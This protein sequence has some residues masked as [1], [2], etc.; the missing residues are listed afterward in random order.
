[1]FLQVWIII[2][3]CLGNNVSKMQRL[4]S[5]FQ[6]LAPLQEQSNKDWC[7]QGSGVTNITCPGKE[8]VC[9]KETWDLDGQMS[10][11]F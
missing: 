1:M 11:F 3:I 2:F 10:T 6:Q 4:Q 5:I 7:G 9:Y 8:M